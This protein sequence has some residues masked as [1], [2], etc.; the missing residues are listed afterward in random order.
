MG[1]AA[2]QSDNL[3]MFFWAPIQAG[4]C[5]WEQLTTRRADGDPH[6]DLGDVCDFNE[7]LI[8]VAENQRR[9]QKWS[10]QQ[11]KQKGGRR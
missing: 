4:L 11:A 5:T 6:Y 9:A 1:F 2:A 8:M 10:E 3:D 7:H